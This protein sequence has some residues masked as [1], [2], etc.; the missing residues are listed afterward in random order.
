MIVL[1]MGLLVIGSNLYAANGDLVVNGVI[2]ST[3][4]GTAP[5][6]V[7]ST[8]EVVNLRAANATKFNNTKMIYLTSVIPIA[9]GAE[10]EVLLD[11]T[12]LNPRGISGVWLVS[13]VG[14]YNASDPLSGMKFSWKLIHQTWD[15]YTRSFAQGGY[16]TSPSDPADPGAAHK[17]RIRV[18]NNSAYSTNALIAAV[19]MYQ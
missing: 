12:S 6:V 10:D 7:N 4:T 3:I 15:G 18:K 5:F 17:V 8:T 13:V 2:T 16:G 9:S 14:G 1:A 11:L 19:Y